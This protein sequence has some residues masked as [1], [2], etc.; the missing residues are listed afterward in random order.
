MLGSGLLKKAGKVLSAAGLV[1]DTTLSTLSDASEV[2]TALLKD[3]SRHPLR[4]LNA[5]MNLA[6][7]HL[8]LS[9]YVTARAAGQKPDPVI[10]PESDDRRFISEKWKKYLPF[11][12]LEQAY[13]L[14]S[15]AVHEWVENIEGLPNANHDQ[16]KFYTR[17]LT[18]AVSPS[19]FLLTNPDVLSITWE[20]KG[21][22]LIDG[23]RQ[24]QHDARKNPNLFNVGMTDASAF[25]VGRNLATTPGKVI[26]Q[27]EMMQLIQY[28]P[29]TESVYKRPVL[30]VPPWINK[31]YIL[32]LSA[33][34]SYIRWLV[35]QGLTVFIISW[36]NPG[37][38]LR[39]KGFEDYMLEG[40]IAA[41]KAI[42][43]ATGEQEIN[44]IGYCL[45]GTLLA[46]SLAWMKKKQQNP[47]ISATYLATLLDFSD[48]GPV[49][50]F[51]NE[52]SLKNID[53]EMNKTG[54]F[55]GRAMAFTFNILRE[56]ELFWS[57]WINNYLKG[58]KLSAFDLLYWNTD[59]TNLPETMHSFYLRTMYLENKL[60]QPDALTLS[61]E[62]INLAEIDIPSF[63]LSARQ[64]HIAKWK[65]TYL[66]AQVH[67]G[68]VQFVLSGSGHIAGVIN[69]PDKQKYGFWVNQQLE[70]DPEVWFNK[71]EQ[72]PGSWWPYWLEWIATHAGEQVPA[73]QPGEGELPALEAAPGSYVKVSTIDALNQGSKNVRQPKTKTAR[74]NSPS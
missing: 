20:R 18:S 39:G 55:D 51:I 38:E 45:G 69:P 9:Y 12:Y 34:N 41:I 48:P 47:V 52:K 42:Q 56:N 43:Q 30:I 50:V 60:V 63:F 70:A 67:G 8:A 32:D 72:H 13:L 35:D 54:V 11:D 65:T 1:K 57:F 26:Y 40:P 46:S 33:K 29:T 25:E 44:A 28:S 23:A 3:F 5:Q 62:T 7:K 37:P 17:Q 71:A 19:N 74:L 73:R 4:L 14:N 24:F 36:V 66:G 53:R 27:N 59:S 31:Y 49:G 21:Q 10:Q 64:D 6:S 2:S 68:D 61:G 16:L 15:S 22:N 58:E